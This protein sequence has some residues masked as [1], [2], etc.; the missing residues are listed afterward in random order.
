MNMLLVNKCFH[1][2]ISCIDSQIMFNF[3]TYS[4]FSSIGT[5][6]LP[7]NYFHYSTSFLDYQ[8]ILLSYIQ[9]LSANEELSIRVLFFIICFN[10]LAY[11]V[12][13]LWDVS[14]KSKIFCS[15][16]CTTNINSD[17]EINLM[18]WRRSTADL[19]SPLLVWTTSFQLCFCQ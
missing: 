11:A 4:H 17:W 3:V 6:I 12:N 7:S 10:T 5:K 9:L 14:C 1:Y 2:S 8:I 19:T 18:D 16:T 15:L 13:L